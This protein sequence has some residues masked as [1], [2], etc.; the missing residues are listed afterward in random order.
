MWRVARGKY[1]IAAPAVTRQPRLRARL[2]RPDE[3]ARATGRVPAGAVAVRALREPALGVRRSARV[4]I[5]GRVFYAVGYVQAAAKRG[6]GGV[7]GF[8]ALASRSLLGMCARDRFERRVA[9]RDH[10]RRP[11]RGRRPARTVASRG[12][13]TRSRDLLARHRHERPAADLAARRRRA[14]A[15]GPD[16]RRHRELRRRPQSE[17]GQPRRRRLHRRHRQDPAARMREARRARDD[18]QGVPARLSADR[19]HRRLRPR[20]AGAGARRRQRRH[21]KSGRAVTVQALGGTGGSRSAPISCAGSR[22]ARRSGSAIR[23][24]KTIARCS[25]APASTSTPIPTTTRRRAASTSTR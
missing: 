17:E 22:P 4:W 7:T 23:A 24:G 11:T 21:R 9:A 20:G 16:P 10:S 13:M 15:E 1:K 19:R 18:R 6:P 14:R 2:P 12:I 5:V 25:R 3:H 8:A